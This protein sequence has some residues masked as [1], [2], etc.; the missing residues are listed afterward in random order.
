MDEWKTIETAPK[1]GTHILAYGMGHG[2]GVMSFD[3]NER[4]FPMQ[5]VA[6]WH[7]HDGEKEVE[8]S[9][10]LYRKEPHRILEGWR[11]Q[12]EFRPTHWMPLPSPPSI[13][14]PEPRT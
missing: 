7:W 2:I 13:E 11:T 9:P 8:V 14:A 10:G 3:A 12:W 1:D 5:G 4:P 6:Y